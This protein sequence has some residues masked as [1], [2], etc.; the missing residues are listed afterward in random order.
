MKT[1]ATLITLI[2]FMLAGCAAAPQPAWRQNAQ[3]ALAG[4]TDAW[5]AGDSNAARSEFAHAR[6]ASTGTGNPVAV[7]QIELVRCAVQTASLD[8]DDCTGFTPL[9]PDVTPAQR[10][11]ADYLA[12]RWQGLDAALLPEQ[13]R[14]VVKGEALGAITDPLARCCGRG[15]WC[16][17][18]LL[19]PPRR[20]PTRAGAGHCWRGW[21]WRSSARRRWGTAPKWRGCS[22]AWRWRSPELFG[23]F[24]G[25]V[26]A[27]RSVASRRRYPARTS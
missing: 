25:S 2:T 5:L 1:C 18:V 19:S 14:G 24:A 8:V 10:A 12:G 26:S 22:G 7:A 11:Y 3:S 13:H 27:R 23:P 15:S 20:R 9:A 6:A 21:V 16:R 4:Y 17:K